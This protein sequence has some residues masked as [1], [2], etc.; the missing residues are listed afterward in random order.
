MAYKTSLGGEEARIVEAYNRGELEEVDADNQLKRLLRLGQRTTPSIEGYRAS[1]EAV[2]RATWQRTGNRK[3]VLRERSAEHGKRAK[4]SKYGQA[5]GKRNQ[6]SS[7]LAKS[8]TAQRKNQKGKAPG[9]DA[10][11][12]E[13]LATPG[14]AARFALAGQGP[15]NGLNRRRHLTSLTKVQSRD[16][17]TALGYDV[18]TP[19]ALQRAEKSYINRGKRGVAAFNNNAESKGLN[20]PYGP[21]VQSVDWLRGRP[22]S[23]PGGAPGGAPGAPGGAAGDPASGNLDAADGNLGIPGGPVEPGEG[24][25]AED[26]AAAA[27]AR[28]FDP[29]EL[30]ETADVSQALARRGSRLR[31]L[32]TRQ[33]GM[34]AFMEGLSKDREESNTATLKQQMEA[35]ARRE[36]VAGRRESQ[37]MAGATS[38]LAQQGII[39][40]DLRAS[41]DASSRLGGKETRQRQQMIEDK[42]ISEQRRELIG[43]QAQ[44]GQFEFDTRTSI[45]DRNDALKQQTFQNTIATNAQNLARDQLGLQQQQVDFAEGQATAGP[46]EEDKLSRGILQAT[47]TNK[48]IANEREYIAWMSEASGANAEEVLGTFER[49]GTTSGAIYKGAIEEV[50]RLEGFLEGNQEGG[51]AGMDPHDLAKKLAN[52]IDNFLQ[53]QNLGLSDPI[54]R[55]VRNALLRGRFEEWFLRDAGFQVSNMGEIIPPSDDNE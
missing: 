20:K 34:N 37:A 31:Q 54:V 22:G 55:G 23:T 3:K 15:D 35:N 40:S 9:S 51:V 28:I 19:R 53:A 16:F 21:E 39:S 17:L 46:S 41:L 13:R 42:N 7:I 29:L 52:T 5:A 32:T 36:G 45:R 2:A 50:G 49:V 12:E 47:L 8:V 10:E 48:Q 4:A 11:Y 1:G 26:E 18:K 25:S 14:S 27:T 43:L 24:L 33:K 38:A 44:R 30:L 6:Y